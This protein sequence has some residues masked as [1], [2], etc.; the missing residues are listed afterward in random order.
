VGSES[1]LKKTIILLIAILFN[2]V[3][4]AASASIEINSHHFQE[5]NKTKPT[6]LWL[7][8]DNLENVNLTTDKA[9]NTS[10]STY[11]EN[12]VLSQLNNYQIN[13]QRVS[14]RRTDLTIKNHNN[15]CTASKIKNKSRQQYSLFSTPQNL[16]LG[17]KLYRLKQQTPLP[18]D[19]I[20]EQ[21]EIISL[22]KLF[23]AEP[24]KVLAIADGISYGKFFDEAISELKP[25][26]VY[27][28]SGV[29]RAEA[30]SKML[31]SKR[32]DYILYFPAVLNKVID[33][34]IQ[35]ESYN[36][37]NAEPYIL[38]HFTCSKNE[39]GQQVINDINKI[40]FKAYQTTEFY[41]AHSQG[42]RPADLT[43]L[44]Q[45]FPNIFNIPLSV[46]MPKNLS[47]SI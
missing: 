14:A 3:S 32:I 10:T 27:V 39:L 20:N 43:I 46:I 13:F 36:I 24:N 40:L 26:N 2:A 12:L 31:I 9:P 29:K 22:K 44:N 1:L 6:I 45:H 4:I 25:N 42:L 33:K 11:T 16:Y 35:L 47:S 17:Y 37:A 41:H 18:N 30:I 8:E 7:I 15:I 28:R 23:M 21:G 5:K 34:D 38:G 19:V